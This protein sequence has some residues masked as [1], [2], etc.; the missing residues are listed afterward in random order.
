MFLD[1]SVK[2]LETSDEIPKG[3]DNPS[4]DVPKYESTADEPQS[5][6]GTKS[7][8]NLSKSL[9]PQ[10]ASPSIVSLGL[11]PME[12]HQSSEPAESPKTTPQTTS[13][14]KYVMLVRLLLVATLLSLNPK[15][16][17]Y[18]TRW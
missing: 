15:V 12:N 17:L 1:S 7:S 16:F 18:E 5:P 4:P 13:V 14:I 3:E 11:S 8:P 6:S 9:C 2:A 10:N